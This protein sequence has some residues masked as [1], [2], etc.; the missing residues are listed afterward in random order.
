MIKQFKQVKVEVSAAVLE[1]FFQESDRAFRV[2]KG[3]PKYARLKNLKRLKNGNYLALFRVRGN[4]DRLFE[5]QFLSLGENEGT[6]RA[7]IEYTVYEIS[8]PKIEIVNRKD[9]SENQA[10]Y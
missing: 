1:S 6:P 9:L 10:Y 3:L 7:D 4:L 2:S 5:D 8:K